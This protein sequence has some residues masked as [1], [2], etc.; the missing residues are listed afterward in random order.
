LPSILARVD[1]VRLGRV[2]RGVR[3]RHR[4]RQLDVAASAG[5]SPTTVSRI[6]RGR[7]DGVAV[8]LVVRVAR[9][10]DIRLDWAAWWRGGELDRMLN[11][12]HAA[13]HEALAALLA[14]SGWVTVP[15]ASFSVYGERGIIDVL[16][17]HP[18][19]RSLL[20]VELK[21]EIVDVQALIGTVD[22]YRRLAPTVARER[23]WEPA[24]VSCWVALRDTPANHRR[25]AAHAAVLRAAFPADGRRMRAWL[26]SPEGRVAALGFLSDRQHRTGIAASAGI[27]RVRRRPARVR[28]G[29]DPVV[30]SRGGR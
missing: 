12:G 27:Q 2:M 10:L 11:A 17:F 9:A 13:M 1:A 24:T 28:S 18:A 7:I 26:R 5:V 15:E 16:A 8:G 21:T 19:T 3:L 4:W 25:L 14:G 6:E 29:R 23:E 22:R 20:V 30:R